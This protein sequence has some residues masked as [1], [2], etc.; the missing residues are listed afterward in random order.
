MELIEHSGAMR[1]VQTL[2]GEVNMCGGGGKKLWNAGAAVSKKGKGGVENWVNN[3]AEYETEWWS[4]GGRDQH[5][6]QG[7]RDKECSHKIFF[8]D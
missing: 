2:I 6:S 8:L 4:H 3:I 1:Q 7:G 5:V